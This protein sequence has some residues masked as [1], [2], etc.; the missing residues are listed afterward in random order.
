MK[1]A[2]HASVS[3]PDVT[4]K[5]DADTYT[6]TIT[7][8]CNLYDIT[9]TYPI[10]PDVVTENEIAPDSYNFPNEKKELAGSAT[11]T[12]N[13]AHQNTLRKDTSREKP[14]PFLPSRNTATRLRSSG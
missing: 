3:I 11:I 6:Y 8:D 12:P 1:V 5:E 2:F 14:S 9:V 7:E 4:Y 13:I 10:L